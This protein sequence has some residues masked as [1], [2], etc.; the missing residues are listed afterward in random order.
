MFINHSLFLSSIF[1][2]SVFLAQGVT[3]NTSPGKERGRECQ[4]NDANIYVRGG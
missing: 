4:Q 3:G 2:S 1:G